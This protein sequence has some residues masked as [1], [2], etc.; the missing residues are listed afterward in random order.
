MLINFIFVVSIT[1]ILILVAIPWAHKNGLLDYPSSRKLHSAP[2]PLVGGLAMMAIL[3]VIIA[4]VDWLNPEIYITNKNWILIGFLSGITFIGLIDDYLILRARYLFVLESLL[5]VLL[6]I[7]T[8]MTIIQLGFLTGSNMLYLG[9]LSAV[10]TWISYLGVINAM[11]MIDGTDGLAGTLALIAFAFF[12]LFAYLQNRPTQMLVCVVICAALVAFLLLNYRLPWN[13]RARTFMGSAG[14]LSIGFLL[15]WSAINLSQRHQ[16]NA[17][18]IAMVYVL[19]V[20]LLDMFQVMV[21]RIRQQQSPFKPDR[22]HLQHKLLDAGFNHDQVVF[23]HALMAILLGCIGFFGWYYHL[24]EAVMFYGF[25]F[26]LAVYVFTVVEKWHVVKA[27]IA[28]K[29]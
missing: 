7:L 9:S 27:Y 13:Q 4:I 22:L 5:I 2:T 15:A 3:I 21:S 24:S 26:I 25:L 29:H 28:S 23:I 17:Y 19:A 16:L 18:P 12:G 6:I 11:N 1:L 10:F 8:D 20:P 14:S